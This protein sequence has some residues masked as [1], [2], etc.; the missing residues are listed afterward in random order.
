MS[1]VLR[2]LE[3]DTVLIRVLVFSGYF[4]FNKRL[5]IFAAIGRSVNEFNF[6]IITWEDLDSLLSLRLV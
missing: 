2:N 1:N 6:E 4:V 5:I 3:R